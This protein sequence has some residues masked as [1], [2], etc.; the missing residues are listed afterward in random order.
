MDIMHLIIFLKKYNCYACTLYPLR[1]NTFHLEMFK[2]PL[3]RGLIFSNFTW[4]QTV[5]ILYFDSFIRNSA[6]LE[7]CFAVSC[8]LLLKPVIFCFEAYHEC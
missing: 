3:P 6:F 4:N 1:K 5:L 8:A 2:R 7:C